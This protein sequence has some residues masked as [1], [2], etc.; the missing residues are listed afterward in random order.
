MSRFV[1]IR[2][3]TLAASKNERS[4]FFRLYSEIPSFEDCSSHFRIDFIQP[5]VPR[6]TPKMQLLKATPFLLAPL[7][8]TLVSADCSGPISY[9][10]CADRITHW[11]D[12]ETGEVCDPL[13]CGGGRAPVKYDVPGC[14]AYTGTVI[15]T[16]TRS[17]LSCWS[18]S[19]VEATTT[20]TTTATVEG[21]ETATATTTVTA[22][23]SGKEEKPTLPTTVVAIGSASAS[24]LTTPAPTATPARSNSA[25]NGTQTETADEPVDTN[26]AGLQMAAGTGSLVAGVAA[27]MG[28]AQFI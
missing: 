13:D 23:N 14:A 10:T 26:A 24:P 8:A 19:T 12:P 25:G 3:W 16:S 6:Y 11:F 15:Y 9:T 27:I 21:S 4:P 18:P 22:S 1:K 2:R 28:L 17:I 7:L 5:I 20:T